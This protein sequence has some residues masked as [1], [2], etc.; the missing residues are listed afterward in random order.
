MKRLI[1]ILY[2]SIAFS[3]FGVADSLEDVLKKNIYTNPQIKAS[4][5]NYKSSLYELEKVKSGN[6]PTLDFSAEYGKEQTEIA[7]NTKGSH[8]LSETQSRLVGSYN[9]FE[10]FKTTH[11]IEEKKSAIEVE[12]NKVFQKINKISSLI[13]QVYL[14]VL[15]AKELLKIEQRNVN[16]HL[17]TLDKVK[18]RLEAGD[19]YESNLRQTKARVALAQA[20]QLIIKKRYKNSEINYRRFMGSVPVSSSMSLPIIAFVVKENQID[21]FI[22]KAQKENHNIKIQASEV[23]IAKSVHQ[24]QQSKYYPTIDVEVSQIWSDNVHG[25][26]GRDDSSK[27]ALVL[28]YNF[29]NGGADRAS[30]RVALHKADMSNYSLEDLKLTIEE[31]IRMSLMKYTM[32]QSQE[33]LIREQLKHL[34]GTQELYELEYQNNKRTIIDVLNIKQEYTY[35]QTQKTHLYYDK[36]LAYYQFKSTM[37]SLI[38][39]FQLDDVLVQ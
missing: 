18:L 14:E 39:E 25:F 16:N 30:E 17:E 19:G 31:Q 29:Y 36:I 32:L 28:N 10:G 12:K 35:A 26:Q 22:K 9:L 7:S 1:N 8:K 23:A 3:S 21:E 13:I 33:K 38:E 6:K 11:K 5:E 24:Q 27:V 15:R 4:I 37:G 2:C 20:N 34:R